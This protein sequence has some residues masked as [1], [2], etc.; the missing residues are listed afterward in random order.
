GLAGRL[1]LA[2]VQPRILQIDASA[3]QHVTFASWLSD[4]VGDSGVRGVLEMLTRVTTFTNDPEHQSAGA[5]VE[6]LQLSLRGSVRYRAG[7]WQTIVDG[8]RRVAMASGVQ[9]VSGG[10]VV[11]LERA[12]ER[13]VGAVRLADGRAVR[14]SGAI[15]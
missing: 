13:D 15:I 7:G 6:Q 8:L 1:E 5:A 9:I 2:R 12:T 4:N 10:Q 11:A 3:I 14:A